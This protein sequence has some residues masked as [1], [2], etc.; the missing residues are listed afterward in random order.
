MARAERLK[1]KSKEEIAQEARANEVAK[2]LEGQRAERDKEQSR[3]KLAEVGAL[4]SS[5]TSAS[6]RYPINLPFLA[7]SLP[8]QKRRRSLWS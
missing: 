4:S 5:Q 7:H 2:E 1:A 6:R 3:H 8:P